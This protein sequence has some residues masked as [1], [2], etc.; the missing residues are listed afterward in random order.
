MSL[1]LEGIRLLALER[2]GAGPYGSGSFADLGADVIKIEHLE[3]GFDTAREGG[4]Y[5]LG[6]HDS[7]YFQ[8]FNRNKRSFSLDLKHDR[9]REVLGRL[10]ASADGLIDNLRGDQPGKLGIT[11]EHLKEHN[12]RLVCAHIS[13]YGREGERRD[14]PGYD[15]LMQ[16]E[17]GFLSVTGEPD[18]PPARFGLSMVD[19]MTGMTAAFA[20]LA[21]IMAA[22]QSGQG[23]DMDVS[24]YDVAMHQLTYPGVW[25][26]NEGLVTERVARSGHPYVAP[27]QLCRTGDGWIF[28]MAQTQK[29]WE[30]LCQ[31]IE[32]PEL[33][34]D[35]RFR[36][37]ADR[38]ENRE[39]LTEVLD[40]ILSAKATADWI[41]VFAGA[42]PCAPVNDIAQALDNPF[43]R[44]RGG[45][46]SVDHPD[47]PDLK[48]IAS[49]IRLDEE[50]PARP[51]PKLG[52]DSDDI[53]RELGYSDDEI[54]ALRD[55]GAV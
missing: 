44:Q 52:A 45:V 40:E 35:A 51:G 36:T 1:P 4:P 11:Y 8:S 10:V 6:D 2:F 43:F 24:L 42:L 26:L 39:E 29:F 32:R 49:P 53:L 21:G 33:V 19:F 17:A 30:I 7:Q 16:A 18:S 13:A 34:E 54:T 5:F 3:G 14:W 55:C 27:S 46:Q 41:D 28:V 23:R 22:R 50:L 31:R 48:L 12:P 9:G 20:L 38:H 47:H 25:Y 37:Y 15:Y